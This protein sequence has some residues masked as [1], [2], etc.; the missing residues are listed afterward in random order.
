ML[1][2]ITFLHWL[3][4]QFNGR[5]RL[6]LRRHLHLLG[7]LGLLS[8]V[9][10]KLRHFL[11]DEL[12]YFNNQVKF[13]FDDINGV[14]EFTHLTAYPFDLFSDILLLLLYFIV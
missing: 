11:Q 3:L 2:R 7:L 10:L 13:L 9:V 4:G 14:C 6:N 5:S 8:L 12:V 1:I